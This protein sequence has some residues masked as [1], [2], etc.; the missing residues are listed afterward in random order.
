MAPNK[1]AQSRDSANQISQSGIAFDGFQVRSF[2]IT[3][4]TE[5]TSLLPK[6]TSILIF[7]LIGNTE[8]VL[9]SHSKDLTATHL[10]GDDVIGLGAFPIIPGAAVPLPLGGG[11]EIYLKPVAGTQGIIII[12]T[13]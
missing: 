12:P 11:F 3:R 5:I 2:Q 9:L 10:A 4:L 7:A 6:F 13:L 1:V 8:N